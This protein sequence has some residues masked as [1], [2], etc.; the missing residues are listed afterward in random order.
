MEL[1]SSSG[2]DQPAGARGRKLA[3]ALFPI[4]PFLIALFPVL[5]LLA[6]NIQEIPISQSYRSLWVVLVGTAALLAAMWLLLRDRLRAAALCSLLLVLLFSYGQVYAVLKTA[7]LG[8]FILGRHRYLVPSFCL[9]AGLGAWLILSRKG[10]LR[11]ASRTLNIVGVILLVMPVYSIGLYLYRVQTVW[12]AVGLDPLPSLEGGTATEGLVRPDVYYIILDGYARSDYMREVFAYD[13]SD[14]L[15]F[16]RDRGFYIADRSVSNHN[17]T[18]LSLASS[19]N[20]EFVQYLGLDLVRGSYP[21]VFVNPIRHSRVRSKLESLGYSTVGMRTGYIPTELDDADHLFSPEVDGLQP[22]SAGPSFYLNAFE[23]MLY[24][25]SAGRIL[26]DFS[27]PEA[28]N[29]VGFR[30]DYPFEVLRGIIL[31]QFENLADVPAIPGPKFVFVH[32]VAPHSPYLFGPNGENIKQT[33]SFTLADTGT[34]GDSLTKEAAQ[35]RDQAIYISSR[36]EETIDTILRDS[37]VSP[38]IILQAD[39]GPSV[40]RGRESEGEG[41]R[42][43]TAILNAYHMPGGCDEHLYPGISPVNSFRIMF[44]CYFDESYELLEDSVY[45]SNWP[46]ETDYLFID[47]SQEVRQVDG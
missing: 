42:Q 10:D 26:A 23:G 6:A 24:R 13:N 33:G 46:R 31:A 38:I 19:L 21:A 18:A 2:S 35:Y 9:I 7:T 39:H 28:K 14:F 32:I 20:M 47:V 29:W 45:F 25:S 8:N 36:V 41:L 44:N 34:A 30:T 16:L 22:V 37:K 4:H 1:D 15:E 5:S 43:R 40:G 12:S 17:W 27:D 3:R 11:V